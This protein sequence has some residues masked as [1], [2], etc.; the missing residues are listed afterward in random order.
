VP[1]PSDRIAAPLPAGFVFGTATAAYQIEGSTEAGG[2]G[3]SIWDTFSHTPGKTHNGDTGDVACRH[4]ERFEED[5]DLMAELGAGAYRFSISW[6][7]IQP[8]GK[9]PASSEGLDFYRRLVSGLRDRGIS[10][11][12][13]L[14]HWD[15]PQPL[16]DAGGWAERDTVSRFAEFAAIVADGLGAEI[17]SWITLNEPWC[18]AWLGYGSGHHAPGKRDIGLALAAHHHLLLAHGEAARAIRAVVPGAR[19]G[20]SLNLQPVRPAS[21]HPDDLAAA[22]RV[23]GNHNRIYTGPLFAGT[24]PADM[25]DHYRGQTPGL[26]VIRDGDLETIALPVDFVGINYYSTATVA[27]QSRAQAATAAGYC[28]PAGSRDDLLMTDLHAIGLARPAFE[29]TAMGWEVEPEGLTELLLMVHAVTPG[30]PVFVTENG[31]ACN[32]YVDPHGTIRD[33]DRIRYLDGHIRAA[34]RAREQGAN[35]AGYLVWSLL[36]NFEW[37]FGYSRRFGLVWMD[38]PSGIRI[39]KDSFRWYQQALARNS[40]LPVDEALAEAQR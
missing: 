26:S 15:L 12:V 2:R 19:V 21:D 27:D 17:A 24:Y 23:D 8:T 25:L 3:P 37:A 7:R 22:R 32:D 33:A 40:L 35:V 1:S 34:L 38:Y 4:Y 30:T 36:D 31:A 10:P 39:A 14:Y 11:M 5:L 13:T 28:V 18:S 16:E 9:G 6:P 29:R 20:I